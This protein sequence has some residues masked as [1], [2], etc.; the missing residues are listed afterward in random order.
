MLN[1]AKDI[2]SDCFYPR[3]R[4]SSWGGGGGHCGGAGPK[5]FIIWLEIAYSAIEARSLLYCR[6]P[7]PTRL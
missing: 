1:G 7:A 2:R 3:Y 4:L 5:I 6:H